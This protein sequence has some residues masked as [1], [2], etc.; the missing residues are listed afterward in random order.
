MYMEKAFPF[1]IENVRMEIES[2]PN[3]HVVY[4]NSGPCYHFWT[5]DI[6]K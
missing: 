4:V 3:L 2:T 5:Q 1:H 6:S